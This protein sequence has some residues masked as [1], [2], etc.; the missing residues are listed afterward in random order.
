MNIVL[1][2]NAGM[3]TGIMQLKLQEE[4]KKR[5]I[6]ATV[7]AVPMVELDEIIEETDAILLAPQIRF[8]EKDIKKLVPE[9]VPVVVISAQDFGL[10]NVKKVLDELMK[11]I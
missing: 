5:N 4:I 7:K 1:V 11:K 10:M 2:C 8:A 3:S 6:D 9:N